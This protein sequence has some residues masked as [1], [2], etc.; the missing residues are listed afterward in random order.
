MKQTIGGWKNGKKLRLLDL[1]RIRKV[2]VKCWRRISTISVIICPCGSITVPFKTKD[3]P[4]CFKTPRSCCN[5]WETRSISPRWIDSNIQLPEACSIL[6]PCI[7]AFC[8][9]KKLLTNCKK[10]IIKGFL[11][12]SVRLVQRK[13]LCTPQCPPARLSGSR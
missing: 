1:N 7:H 4:F 13:S 8:R 3:S 6:S 9:L 10:F 5:K 11:N 2:K 12:C